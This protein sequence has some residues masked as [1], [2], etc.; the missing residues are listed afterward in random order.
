MLAIKSSSQVPFAASSVT[1]GERLLGLA[2]VFS[3]TEAD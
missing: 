2:S 1:F 3:Q